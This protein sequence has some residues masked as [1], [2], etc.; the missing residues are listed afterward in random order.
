MVLELRCRNRSLQRPILGEKVKMIYAAA[1]D[2][3]IVVLSVKNIERLKEG[4]PLL[5]QNKRVVI[6]YSP[7]IDWVKD[8]IEAR[9]HANVLTDEMSAEW[10]L[11]K[12]NQSLSRPENPNERKTGEQS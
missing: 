4:K 8:Q 12:V 2:T 5:T 1:G 9:Q 10:L 7:D 6:M 3:H 11:T